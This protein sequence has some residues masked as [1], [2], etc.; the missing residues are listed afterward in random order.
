MGTTPQ[1]GI[2]RLYRRGLQDAYSE[3][4]DQT[5]PARGRRLNVDTQTKEHAVRGLVIIGI[6]MILVG[7][8]GL[9]FNIVPIHHTEEVAKIGPLI[10]TQDKETDVAI[11]T[12]VAVIVIV[13]GGG[14]IFAGRP[15]G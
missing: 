14:L 5:P 9:V 2:S 6:V 13:A 12:F 1:L 4:M 7:I 10:A 15:R 3:Q 11:P 8:G